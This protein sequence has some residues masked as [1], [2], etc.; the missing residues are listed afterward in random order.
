MIPDILANA[1]GVTVS[2][3][4]WQQNVVRKSGA[5]AKTRD[6][7]NRDLKKFMQEAFNN[8]WAVHEGYGV[9]LRK[10][11]YMLGIHRVTSVA[12]TFDEPWA[13]SYNADRLEQVLSS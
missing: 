1:G 9:S 2:Y 8:V 7:V 4:E 12:K 5:L 10:A 3:F 11:A 6:E 13:L